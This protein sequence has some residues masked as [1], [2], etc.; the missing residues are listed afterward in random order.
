MDINK[1]KDTFFFIAS[2]CLLVILIIF[3]AIIFASILA[4]PAYALTL[5]FSEC[6]NVTDQTNTT[7]TLC[8]P[9]FPAINQIISLNYSENY[10]NQPY[11]LTV[12]APPYGQPYIENVTN[13][14]YVENVTN[15][16]WIQN[17][18]FVYNVT[19][20]TVL[21][22]ILNITN[23]TG[24]ASCYV[25][26]VTNVTYIQNTTNPIW[27]QNTT[28]VQNVTYPTWVQNITVA[29][30]CTNTTCPVCESVI[31]LDTGNCTVW[32]NDLQGKPL[33]L[34]SRDK[35]C[36]GS[37]K[38]TKALSEQCQSSLNSTQSRLTTVNTDYQNL[39]Q[40]KDGFD[41][42]YQVGALVVGGLFAIRWWNDREKIKK[43]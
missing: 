34:D 36:L 38:E 10:T 22:Y 6:F 8:A 40:S 11:N 26:N 13:F 39:Q 21:N 9:A 30:N 14:T 17:T 16:T 1:V 19:N 25:E 41:S 28:F 42:V 29:G 37:C 4:P 35:L 18:T 23:V 5:G 20:T 31:F 32:I 12:Q 43:G 33:C 24:N 7:I 3:L 15:V 27:I 2:M